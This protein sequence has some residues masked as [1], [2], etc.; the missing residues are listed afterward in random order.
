MTLSPVATASPTGI[1]NQTP[2]PIS[3]VPTTT[4]GGGNGNG[5]GNSNGTPPALSQG[6]LFGLSLSSFIIGSLILLGIV[7]AI[8]LSLVLL[9]KRLL[10]NPSPQVNLPPSGAQPWKRVRTESLNGISNVPGDEYFSPGSNIQGVT[11]QSDGSGPP[12]PGMGY[13]SN[14]NN[15]TAGFPPSHQPQPW[16]AINRAPTQPAGFYPQHTNGFPP[17]PPNTPPTT[18]YPANSQL[19][20]NG[21]MPASNAP[22]D[23]T[24]PVAWEAKPLTRHVPPSVR[25]Q[26]MESSGSQPTAYELQQ[27]DLDR[28]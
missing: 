11:F 3:G 8:L 17:L 23:S 9:R 13:A 12:V 4:N 19:S 24:R 15:V 26:A 1:G 2:S 5:G 7:G 10:P 18:G 14:D 6:G 21:F 25:L 16:N 20:T 27:Q 22:L 28:K